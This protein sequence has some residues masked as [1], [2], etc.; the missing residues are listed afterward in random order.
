MKVILVPT[1][2]LIGAILG[3]VL[4]AK[5]IQWTGSTAGYVAIGVGVLTG[6]GMLLTSSQS[7]DPTLLKH[8]LI[9][10]VGAA[11]F[12]LVGIV[13]GKYLD[14]RWNAITQ[15]AEQIIAGEPLISEEAA[16]AIAETQYSGTPKW[17]LMKSRMN[18]FDLLFSVVAVFVAFY[19][20]S[21]QRIRKIFHRL[22]YNVRSV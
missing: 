4:W 3:G 8:W 17:E 10:S 14:V 5:C 1:G 7:I 6:F 2:G 22:R 9:L 19:I 21:N 18:W 16:T 15:M 13:I 11:F 12:A 20:T